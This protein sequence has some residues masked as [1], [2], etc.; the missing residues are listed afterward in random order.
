MRAECRRSRRRAITPGPPPEAGPDGAA[1]GEFLLPRRPAR[2][3][4]DR[5][6]GAPDQ[7]QERDGS[8][9]KEQRAPQ[10]LDIT[11]ADSANVNAKFLGKTVGGLL[12]E[13]FKQRL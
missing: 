12:G 9:Q 13:L 6:I 10:M 8:E 2:H 7:Q 1:D 11:I 4:E 5:Y 3:E